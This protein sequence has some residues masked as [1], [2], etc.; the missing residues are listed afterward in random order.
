MAS[1]KLQPMLEQLTE[2]KLPPAW[3]SFD[4]AAF[5]RKTQLWDYQQAALKNA[6]KALWKYYS[7]PSLSETERKEAYYRWY[8]G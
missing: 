3:N 8:P 2:S 6:L 1:I 7:Q 5:S 4:L